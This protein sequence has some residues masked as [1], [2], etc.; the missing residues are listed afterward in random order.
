[1]A[2]SHAVP[3]QKTYAVRTAMTDGA[4]HAIDFIRLKCRRLPTND[5]SYAAHN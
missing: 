1:M 3:A 2:Q 4:R 5:S